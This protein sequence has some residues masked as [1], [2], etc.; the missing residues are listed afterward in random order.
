MMLRGLRRQLSRRQA[1]CDE[2]LHV[3]S[4]LS[5]PAIDIPGRLVHPHL[6]SR[7]GRLA[8]ARYRRVVILAQMNVRLEDTSALTV[9]ASHQP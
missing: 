8:G 7:Q 4:P 5:L 9:A 3:Q 1:K 6:A 2:A